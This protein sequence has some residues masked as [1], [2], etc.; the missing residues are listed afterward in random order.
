MAVLDVGCVVDD[1]RG[2]EAEWDGEVGSILDTD[3]GLVEQ[4]AVESI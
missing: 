2:K 3:D 4:V 1:V